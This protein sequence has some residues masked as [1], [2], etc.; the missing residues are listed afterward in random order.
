MASSTIRAPCEFSGSK[1]PALT[2]REISHCLRD[3]P[4]DDRRLEAAFRHLAGHATLPDFGVASRVDGV[5]DERAFGVI[6]DA[7]TAHADRAAHVAAPAADTDA[8]AHRVALQLIG[9][10]GL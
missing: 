10:R 5:H 2:R 6:A 9:A 8:N 1:F 7:R 4:V 3:G